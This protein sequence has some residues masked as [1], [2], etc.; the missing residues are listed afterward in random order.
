[1]NKQETKETSVTAARTAAEVVGPPTRV[2]LR[3]IFIIIVVAVVL[4]IIVRLTGVI[5]LLVLSIFFAYLVSPLVDFIRRPRQLGKRAIEIPRALAILLAYLII[6]GAIVVA[7]TV[8][9]PS[10]GN[11]FPEFAAQAKGYWKTIGERSQELNEFFRSRRMPGPLVDAAN[12]A[13]PKVVEK[14]SATASEVVSATLAYLTFIPWLILIPILAFFLLKDVESFRRS[15][16]QMLPR[17]RWRWRGDEFFQDVNSTLAAYTRAQLTACL[18]IGL[19]CSLGFTVL[20]LP[21]GLVMGFMAGVFEFVPLVG[22]LMIAITAALLAL[23]HAG[24][25][26]ALLILLFL[27]VLRIAQDYFIYPRLIGQGIHLHPLAVIFAILSGAELAG[28]AGIFLAIPVV[29]ILTVSYRHWMEHRGS[30]GLADLLEPTP[31]VAVQETIKS[32]LH[33]NAKEL[34]PHHHQPQ[35]PDVDTTP[36]D[37]AR[38]RPDL[39]TGE[40]KMPE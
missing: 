2:I 20:G 39:T 23:L 36:E 16:L 35:H 21:G 15:A 3:V 19:V 7:I 12:N 27:G 17:G 38:A 33:E 24:P 25:F 1:V 10:L 14:V 18:L 22:P 6:L 40:L 32:P 31:A 4:W 34:H 37:M 9:L 5:L 11:Q 8:V 30:E 29:A 28:V 13:V 26:S